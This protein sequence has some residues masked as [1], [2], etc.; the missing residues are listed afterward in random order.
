MSKL[1][2][3]FSEI[4]HPKKRKF[5][6]AFAK[7]GGVVRASKEAGCDWTSHY[8]WI[9]TDPLY[10]EVFE[11]AKQIA[12]DLAEEEVYR[13]GILG[14][15]HPVTYEGRITDH[16]RDYSDT[17]AIFYLKGLRPEKYR[18]N[19][20]I[21][22]NTEGPAAIQINLAGASPGAGQNIDAQPAA[23]CEQVCFGDE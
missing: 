18:D 2:S 7:C 12:G 5:L 14:Y 23:G 11:R 6:A 3:A 1:P 22:I 16:Y 9:K 4:S 21:N 17:L 20:G 8:Y 10:C 19:A 13:R 15:D